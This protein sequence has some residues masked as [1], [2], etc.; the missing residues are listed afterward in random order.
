MSNWEPFDPA[1]TND[2]TP[3]CYAIYIRGELVY[4]GQTINLA[5]RMKTHGFSRRGAGPTTTPW[6]RFFSVSAKR[7][8][9]M[10]Y[11]DW[12]MVELRLIRR[13]NPRCNSQHSATRNRNRGGLRPV[14][15]AKQVCME[16]DL[17][18]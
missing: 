5:G 9:V 11:G 3:A 10:R 18:H 17:H 13:L 8:R 16:F 7:R 14:R 2:S 1:T 6:G 15:R 12:A 4:V